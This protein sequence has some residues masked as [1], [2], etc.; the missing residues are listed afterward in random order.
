MT[1]QSVSVGQQWRCAWT[2]GHFNYKTVLQAALCKIS[3]KL[4]SNVSNKCVRPLTPQC[5]D[6]LDSR[7]PVLSGLLNVDAKYTVCD[8]NIRTVGQTG[9]EICLLK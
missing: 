2:L 4:E 8:P 9:P 7:G 1:F 3:A 5:G 6:Q